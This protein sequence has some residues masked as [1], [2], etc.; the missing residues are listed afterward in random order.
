MKDG[1]SAIYGSDAVA[2]VVN[3]MMW[4]DIRDYGPIY[5]G[6]EFE[7]RYGTTTDRDANVRQAWIRGGVTGL[8]GKVAIFA[9]AEYYNRAALMSR[10]ASSRSAG[11]NSSNEPGSIIPLLVSPASVSAASITIAP[12]MPEIF[13]SGL[14]QHFSWGDDD[15]D[16]FTNNAP[17]PASYRPFLGG[18]DPSRFNFR[19]FTPAI[20]AMEKAF[21]YVTGRYK[22]FGDALQIYGDMLYTHLRQN[23]GLAGAPFA[24]GAAAR[25]GQ[26]TLQPHF[27]QRRNANLR[28]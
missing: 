21:N 16:R 3:F 27:P 26:L 1:A 22:I 13:I 15:F 5:E 18:D 20:P 2:G 7:L 14:I 17:T 10:I 6:A 28:T 4:N 25:S 8:D 24:V 19:A 23:N 9:A 12:P 11:D